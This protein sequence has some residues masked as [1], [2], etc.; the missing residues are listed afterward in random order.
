MGRSLDL[1]G[2]TV[3]IAC[4][5]W[6]YLWGLIGL[7]LA[8]P[9]TVS[10]KLVFQTVPELNKWAELMSVDWQSPETAA[11]E[12]ANAAQVDSPIAGASGEH[13]RTAARH[14]LRRNPR[15]EIAQAS[16]LT[17][18]LRYDE[19]RQRQRQSVTDATV[20]EE[21]SSMEVISGIL[22]PLKL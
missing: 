11:T 10:V 12:P 7:I 2:T 8:M 15:R 18:R 14:L 9:I 13:R 6:G 16:R 3:L 1:N 4:L 22:C 20:S 17:G 5:F 19:T 21:P